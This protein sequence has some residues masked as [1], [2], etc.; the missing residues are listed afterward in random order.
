MASPLNFSIDVFPTHY[1]RHLCTL[2]EIIKVRRNFVMLNCTWNVRLINNIIYTQP[3][4]LK[5]FKMAINLMHTFEFDEIPNFSRQAGKLTYMILCFHIKIQ[6]C[7]FSILPESVCII[8]PGF[9]HENTIY[10]IFVI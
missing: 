4:C 6:Q 9:L 8:V 2:T 1:V 5:Q 7:V 10:C 3:Y